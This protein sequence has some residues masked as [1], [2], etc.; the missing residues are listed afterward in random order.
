MLEEK[1]S[2][3]EMKKATG[4]S[5]T[6]VY[7]LSAVAKERVENTNMPL[8]VHHVAN[9]PRSGRPAITV[10]AISCVL[11]VVL[12]N[13]TTRGFSCGTIAKKVRKRGHKVAPRTV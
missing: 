11:K 7:A 2:P 4:V 8:E 3:A 5:R 13:S 9:A 6:R 12:Q 10:E 1:K